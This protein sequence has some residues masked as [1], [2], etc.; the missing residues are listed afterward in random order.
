MNILFKIFL[1]RLFTSFVKK[2]PQSRVFGSL[3]SCHHDS[4]INSEWI[5][6]QMN[7]FS[8]MTVM[9]NFQGINILMQ[10][11]RETS[12]SPDSHRYIEIPS[13]RYEDY[14]NLLKSHLS[15]ERLG[16][17]NQ[18]TGNIT[19]NLESCKERIITV[20]ELLR[21][22][23]SLFLDDY[24]GG[25]SQDVYGVLCEKVKDIQVGKAWFPY[26]CNDRNVTCDE[27]QI[28]RSYATDSFTL[29]T[30]LFPMH[31]TH[32]RRRGPQP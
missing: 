28:D 13:G 3:I 7:K 9:R 5:K 26:S 8:K 10:N 18:S 11:E 19:L 27:S 25:D 32:R 23:W 17:L 6:S 15:A 31:V 30:S 1:S 24:S 29:A 2:D 20:D 4:K 22:S 21:G 12:I 14:S 16:Y